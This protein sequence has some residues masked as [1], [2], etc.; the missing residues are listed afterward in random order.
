[1]PQKYK[2]SHSQSEKIKYMINIKCSEIMILLNDQKPC[3]YVM[4]REKICTSFRHTKHNNA[5]HNDNN[6]IIVYMNILNHNTLII[7][8]CKLYVGIYV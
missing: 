5:V 8:V 6:I 7:N 3:K 2:L 4:F 1:M